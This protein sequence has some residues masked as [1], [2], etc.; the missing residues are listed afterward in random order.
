MALC[1]ITAVGSGNIG[2]IRSTYD[3]PAGEA[4]MRNVSSSGMYYRS[5]KQ[6][7]NCHRSRV[8]LGLTAVA[9]AGVVWSSA[10][11]AETDYQRRAFEAIALNESAGLRVETSGWFWLE[12]DAAYLNA[13]QPSAQLPL[14][15]DL[16]RISPE[17]RESLHAQCSSGGQFLGGCSMTV[18]GIVTKASR[19]IVFEAH[20]IAFAAKPD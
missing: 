1:V 10:A 18:Q 9:V 5:S 4:A 8:V 17:R 19:Q 20:S 6:I 12:S 3:G 15:V 16:T 2:V 14:R 13:N 11:H 7:M